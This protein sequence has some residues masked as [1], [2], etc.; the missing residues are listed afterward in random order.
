MLTDTQCRTEKQKEKLYRINDLNGLYLEVKPN[1]KK[2]LRY[3]FKLNGKYSM[4]ALGEYSAV[5]SPR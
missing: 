1:S 2:A 3:R 5:K 4:F